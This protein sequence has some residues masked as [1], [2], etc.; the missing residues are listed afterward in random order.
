MALEQGNYIDDK[1]LAVTIDT[2]M[3]QVEYT[4][5][6]PPPVDENGDPTGDPATYHLLHGML[7]HPVYVV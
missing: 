5:H 3:D 2:H 1:T 4:K 7:G 6:I